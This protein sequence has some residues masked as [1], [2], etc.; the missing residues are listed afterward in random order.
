MGVQ[1]TKI[2]HQTW[3]DNRI[4]EEFQAFSCSWR[5]HHPG[6][7][8]RL[9]TNADNLDFIRR[10]YHWFLPFFDNY[11]LDIQ[12]ADAVRYFILYTYGGVYVDLDFECFKPI[13][14]LLDDH[15]CVL[16]LEP[17]RHCQKHGV[18]QIIS[19]AFMASVPR[20]PLFYAVAKDMAFHVPSATHLNDLVLE[21][22]GPIMLSRVYSGFPDR[23]TVSL[24]PPKF[25]FPFDY[26]EAR[27]FIVSHDS[28]LRLKLRDSYGVHY[29]WGSWWRHG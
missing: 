1:I 16:A 10:E 20:H 2:I 12:R 27:R 23:E 28:Q 29:H 9:W 7:E 19:N 11:Q 18:E 25:L 8:Y 24:L 6:W 5:N 3:K 17:E 14:P 4:P 21:T 15:E 22:T 26:E 13:E